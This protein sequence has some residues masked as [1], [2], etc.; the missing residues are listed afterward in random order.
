M[1]NEEVRGGGNGGTENDFRP[2]AIGLEVGR[3][4]EDTAFAGLQGFSTSE[5]ESES[6]EASSFTEPL[7]DNVSSPKLSKLARLLLYKES[8]SVSREAASSPRLG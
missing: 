4:G 6:S 8:S 5:M 1:F 3:G 2:K 7:P